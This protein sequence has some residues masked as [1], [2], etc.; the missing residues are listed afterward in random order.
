[1]N[2]VPHWQWLI[3]LYFIIV[4]V[5]VLIVHF[6]VKKLLLQHKTFRN[7]II[8]FLAVTVTAFITSFIAMFLYYKFIFAYKS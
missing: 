7:L 3:L 6:K 8:Y 5:P 2:N 1:M 4:A